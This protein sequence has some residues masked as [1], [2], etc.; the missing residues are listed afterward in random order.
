[1]FCVYILVP[2]A[3][4]NVQ[5]KLNQD[6]SVT[7]SWKPPFSKGGAGLKYKVRY[8]GKE[9]ITD[10]TYTNIKS[11]AEDWSYTIEVKDS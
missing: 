7:V 1:M 11:G 10:N 9:F 2:G 8:G 3:V 5:T 4:Q 6:A